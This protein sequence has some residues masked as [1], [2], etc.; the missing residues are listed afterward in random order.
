M[1]QVGALIHWVFTCTANFGRFDA[2]MDYLKTAADLV[3]LIEWVDPK[4]QALQIFHHTDCGATPQEP[5]EVAAFERALRRI[6]TIRERWPHPN[7]PTRVLYKVFL[8]DQQ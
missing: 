8:E 4:D 6:G 3:L 5:Y 2:I 7:R 1:S